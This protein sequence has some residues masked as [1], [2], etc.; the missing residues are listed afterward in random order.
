MFSKSVKNKAREKA[1]KIFIAQTGY[2]G[3]TD[4]LECKEK[5]VIKFFTKSSYLIKVKGNVNGQLVESEII[6]VDDEYFLEN[7]TFQLYIFV[8]SLIIFLLVLGIRNNWRF[9]EIIFFS[10]MLFGFL[11]FKCCRKPLGDNLKKIADTLSFFLGTL[12]ACSISFKSLGI[13]VKTFQFLPDWLTLSATYVA[14][15]I[16]CIF[17]TVKFLISLFDLLSS[18]ERKEDS[19]LS[20]IL[21]KLS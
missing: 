14:I 21:R 1:K 6:I 16:L 8:Y 11:V 10:P 9:Y 4:N 5:K 17:I 7:I 18:I 3:P 15:N 19:I 2:S 12:T 20:K 13:K